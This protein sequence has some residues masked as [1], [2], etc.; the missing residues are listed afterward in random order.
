MDQV[1]LNS[2]LLPV[3]EF[4]LEQ[5]SPQNQ[6]FVMVAINKKNTSP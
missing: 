3:S 5:H 1:F 6:D 4:Q 2:L